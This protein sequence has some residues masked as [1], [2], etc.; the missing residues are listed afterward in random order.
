MPRVLVVDDSV[1]MR[2]IVRA[3]LSGLGLDLEFA[4]SAE[5][6]LSRMAV[7]PPYDLVVTDYAMPGINGLEFAKRIKEKGGITAPRII[8]ISANKELRER[9]LL[10]TGILDAFFPKPLDGAQLAAR[11][12]SILSLSSAS[13]AA[14]IPS[15]RRVRSAI[16]VVVADDTEVGRTLLMRVLKAD[17]ELDVVGVAR[18]GQQAVDLA[19]RENPQ[20]ILLDA[21]MPGL[22]GVAA[23]RRIMALAP[24]R[25]VI[26]SEQQ[27]KGAAAQI[28]AA[29]EAGAIDVIARPG[30]IDPAGPQ[31]V[32][33]RDK[34]KMLAEIPV[35][36]RWAD[37]PRSVRS[38]RG[39]SGRTINKASIVAICASTGGPAAL[40]TLLPGIAAVAPTVPILIVQHVLAG[41]DEALAEWLAQVTQLPVRIATQGM[42]I[43]GGVVVLAPEGK[44]L[45]AQSS[46]TM[47]VVET[48]PIASH[49]PSGTPL[50]ESIARHFGDGALAVVLT[51]M[52]NDGVEGLRAVKSVGGTVLVQS[53]D[54]CVV[55]GMPGAAIA[56]GYADSVLPLDELALE[57]VDRVRAPARPKY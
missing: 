40:A 34:I 42:Q 57:I 31:A 52:G 22:D 48:P 47:S 16:R 55:S 11:V 14:I 5:E 15:S 2:D 49:R 4:P 43:R 7:N 10:A 36:R 6:G 29:T 24:T 53:P 3:H 26:V 37:A 33:L 56:K 30:W 50:F 44:H 28:F 32:A 35:V 46:H 27:G 38:R 39:S 51:G 17:T 54:T 41:F 18:D 9:D 12:S 45:I 21:M 19:V 23:T 13:P 8:L 1:V 25:V 20:I